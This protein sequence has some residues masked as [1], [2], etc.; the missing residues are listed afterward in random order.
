MWSFGFEEE[1]Y[2][3]PS[4]GLHVLPSVYLALSLFLFQLYLVNCNSRIAH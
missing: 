3:C 4:E 1:K 2:L